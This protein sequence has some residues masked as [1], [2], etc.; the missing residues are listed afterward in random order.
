MHRK[1]VSFICHLERV[2]RSTAQFLA[3]LRAEKTHVGER[4]MRL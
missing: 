3:S 2:M 4:A 1:K